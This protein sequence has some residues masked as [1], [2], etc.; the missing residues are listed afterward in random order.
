MQASPRGALTIEIPS[1][2]FGGTSFA[3]SSVI[4][5]LPAIAMIPVSSVFACG[6]YWRRTREPE[7]SAATSRSPVA[8]V[9]SAKYAVTL[10]AVLLEA[11]ELLAEL[12]H[13][14]ETGQQHLAQRHPADR[15]LALHRVG[16]L[17]GRSS[18]RTSLRS[19]VSM[20]KYFGS[21]ALVATNVS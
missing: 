16:R 15:L 14:V 5:S 7:P 2:T 4:G 12:D 11:G 9:P 13:V 3:L 17:G 18:E 20:L 8:C 19:S 1:N 6:R 21:R 10:V